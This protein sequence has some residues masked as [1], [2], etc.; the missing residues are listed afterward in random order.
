MQFVW[1]DEDHDGDWNKRAIDDQKT[2]NKHL[3]I[4]FFNCR[5]VVDGNAPQAFT[6]RKKNYMKTFSM[7]KNSLFIWCE[8]EE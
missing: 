8:V 4:Y 6:D 1:E 7:S 5:N 3:F 2:R